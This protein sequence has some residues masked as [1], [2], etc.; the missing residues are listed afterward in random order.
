MSLTPRRATWSSPMLGFM[1]RSQKSKVSVTLSCQ[2]TSGTLSV[3]LCGVT[4]D[5]RFKM[6]SEVEAEQ[7][8]K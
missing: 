1:T 6:I 2:Q 7:P 3:L 5:Q 4:C 8:T